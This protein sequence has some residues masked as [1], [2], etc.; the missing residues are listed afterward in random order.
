MAASSSACSV[1]LADRRCSS[2]SRARP[3]QLA[4]GGVVALL[5]VHGGVYVLG[6]SALD[7]VIGLTV[8]GVDSGDGAAGRGHARVGDVVAACGLLCGR[9]RAAA[10]RGRWAV[11]SSSAE[12]R[13]RRPRWLVYEK[14]ASAGAMGAG[15]FASIVR[16]QPA[17]NFCHQRHDEQRHD[18]DDLDGQVPTAG[19]A[20]SPWQGSP[21]VSPVTA[22]LCASEPLPPWW[23][24]SM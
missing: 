20:M 16:L 18:V 21:T 2:K 15:S 24:S 6:R 8:G 22:A 7:L 13:S 19:P 4:P 23:P 11:P 14:A 17:W 3:G 1:I 5:R 9:L 10:C 12:T